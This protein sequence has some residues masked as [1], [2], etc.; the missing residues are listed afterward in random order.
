MKR[1]LLLALA[2][3]GCYSTGQV[4]VQALRDLS[5]LHGPR[6][7]KG[8][9]LE[10]ST[11]IRAQLSDGSRTGWFEAGAVRVSAEGL[12]LDDPAAGP[13]PGLRWDDL[14][15]FELRSLDPTWSALTVPLFPLVVLALA[16]DPDDCDRA[17][18]PTDGEGERGLPVRSWSTAPAQELFTAPARRRALV[19]GLAIADA[20][21]SYRGDLAGGLTAGF[22]F[23][24]FY[25]LGLVGRPLSLA[26]VEPDGGRR[27]ALAMG[28]SFG[29]H[30]DGDGD[31]RFAFYL[32]GEVVGSGGPV[33]VTAAQLKWGPRLGLGHGL[34][35]TLS[36]ANLATM[37]VA[38]HDGRPGWSLQR[39]VTSVELGG[40]L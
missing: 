32:G 2:L 23:H 10:P 27:N 37:D 7:V 39:V 19:Q 36:P 16:L 20:Q 31:P 14:R 6:L 38:A 18:S 30:I 22:R 28:F 24:D 25:E 4:P 1:V 17:M 26:G 29:I 5:G 9:L 34:F 40:T 8:E 11:M 33:K 13:V 35:L 21:G 15:G 3:G 12:T